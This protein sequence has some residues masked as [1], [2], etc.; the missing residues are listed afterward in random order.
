MNR[1]IYL[2]S[3]YTDPA[4]TNFSVGVAGYPEKHY[5]API[6]K[7][8]CFT[9]KRKWKQEQSILLPKCFLTTGF[10]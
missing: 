3:Y 9:L 4:H 8:T 10:F 2:E 5:E 6:L 7:L 1:G